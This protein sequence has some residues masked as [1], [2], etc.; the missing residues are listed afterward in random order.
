MGGGEYVF[1][2]R[3]MGENGKWSPYEAHLPITI[4]YPFWQQWW[5]V[6]LTTIATG[7]IIYLLYRTFVL[8]PQNERRLKE[9]FS[10]QLAESELTALRAQMNPHFLFNSLNSINHQVISGN[11]DKASTYLEHFSR[12]IRKILNNSRHTSISV[13]DEL[14]AL[15]LYIKLEQLRFE[16]KFELEYNNY[17]TAED[18][19]LM[20]PPLLLQPYVENTIWQGLMHKKGNGVLMLNIKGVEDKLTFV[21]EDNG[22]GRKASQI[23]HKTRQKHKESM[24]MNITKERMQLSARLHGLKIEEQVDDLKENDLAQGT[25]VTITISDI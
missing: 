3:V 1:K 11:T 17:L 19:E 9:K 21:I 18:K 22:M 25:R 4:S 23:S 8:N 6:L 13:D 7:E 24:G 20:I 16:N 5:F 10:K 14:E 15:L 2:L 12:L